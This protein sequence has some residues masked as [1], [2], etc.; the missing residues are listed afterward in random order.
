MKNVNGWDDEE[1]TYALFTSHS[2]KKKYKKQI[3]GRYAYCGEY[4]HKAVD[5]PNKKAIRKR[6][7]RGNLIR[8]R[9]TLLKESTGERDIKICPRLNATI[10]E[11]MAIMHV[12]VQNNMIMLNMA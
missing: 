12:T 2:S 4:A 1:D 11:N 6:V 5:C 7:S 9:S 3:K 8:K 10:M